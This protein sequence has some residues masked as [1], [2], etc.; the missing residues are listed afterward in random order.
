MESTS[1]SKDTLFFSSG[2]LGCGAIKEDLPKPENVANP[3]EG[4]SV[5]K[6]L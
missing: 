6:N 5:M 2:K 4:N 3:T 1:K